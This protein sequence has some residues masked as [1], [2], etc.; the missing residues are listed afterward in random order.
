MAHVTVAEAR[1]IILDAI[2]VLGTERAFLTDAA[3]RIVAETVVAG[4][5]IPPWDN[6]AMDGFAVRH[7][8]V[9][10]ASEDAARPLRV[11]ED[12]PAGSIATGSVGEGT[13]IRIMTGAPVPDGA[14]T[15]V[16]VELTRPT[17]EDAIEVFK[18]PAR[19]SNIRAKGEDIDEG[20]VVLERGMRLT[21]GAIGIAASVGRAYL[22]VYQR[23]RVAILSTG[24]E[25]AEVGTVAEP[26]QIYTS[27]SYTLAALCKQLGAHPTYLG[28]AADTEESL[29]EHLTAALS[30]D[31]IIT[32]GGV[33]VGD[34]DFVKKVLGDLG[35]DMKF[36]KVAQ[37]PGH[38]LA[39]G[40][41]GGK[42]AFGLPGNPVSTMV[43]FYLYVRPSLLK[44][45]GHT[46]IHPP[47]LEAELTTDVDTRGGKLYLLR[48]TLT[49]RSDGRYE[50]ASTG[51]QGSGILSSM[52]RGNCLML[53]PPEKKGAKA[54]EHL[55]VLVLDPFLGWGEEGG[56]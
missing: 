18:A 52:A 39:F 1:Q 30:C 13:A 48:G 3:D 14:D 9:D 22:Q 21:P 28:I 54:G 8:D 43:S 44:M 31:A 41:I 24:D 42:P 7:A 10:G 34:Y 6:S 11:V 19:G 5:S 27:N 2:E 16:P 53:V 51:A 29:R 55:Q 33:S 35:S 45:Q 26:G 25:I 46:Q 37:R 49:Q 40:V 56:F 23:P 20:D 17:G 50:V 36:W 15:V 32:T 12:V 47:L 38:P 4:R